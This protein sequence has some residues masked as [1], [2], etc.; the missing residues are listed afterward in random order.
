MLSNGA[1]ASVAQACAANNVASG[2]CHG[3]VDEISVMLD[4]QFAPK[5]DT[6]VGTAYS[7][8]GG[9]QASGFIV[10]NNWSTTAGVRFRW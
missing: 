8:L 1:S 3:T 6:Y 9:G 7:K 10:D 4:W 5:W 2:N